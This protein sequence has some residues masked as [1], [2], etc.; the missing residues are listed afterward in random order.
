VP[1]A[2]TIVGERT[3]AGVLVE[4]SPGLDGGDDTREAYDGGE[5]VSDRGG[6]EFELSAGGGV[7]GL[8]V[9]TDADAVTAS[10]AVEEVILSL[11]SISS[12]SSYRSYPRVLGS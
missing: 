5:L 8:C 7:A 3:W 10:G 4:D 6:G 9:V 1:L 11:I 12:S 2:P